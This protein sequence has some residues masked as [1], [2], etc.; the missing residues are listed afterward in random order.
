MAEKNSSGVFTGPDY[1]LCTSC[2]HRRPP[3]KL[4]EIDGAFVCD[5]KGLCD[6]LRERRVPPG[7]P[8]AIGP[9]DWDQV[10]DP[11]LVRTTQ[12]HRSRRGELAA[13]TAY[14]NGKAKG[15]NDHG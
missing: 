2:G 3:P 15:G 6:A 13:V 1:K 5:D 14:S 10:P 8:Y 12:F 4:K 11:P 9:P 7:E